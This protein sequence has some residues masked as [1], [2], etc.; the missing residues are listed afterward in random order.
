MSTEIPILQRDLR[1][2][3][4]FLRGLQTVVVFG[5]MEVCME[6]GVPLIALLR[7]KGFFVTSS[8]KKVFEELGRGVRRELN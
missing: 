7:D 8:Q 6:V 5:E 4:L 1:C 2:E 3:P